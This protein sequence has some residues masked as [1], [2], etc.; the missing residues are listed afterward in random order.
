MVLTCQNFSFLSAMAVFVKKG[1]F[2]KE[3]QF[4]EK[5]G[6]FW[7]SQTSDSFNKKSAL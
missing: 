5:K 3:K 2:G 4:L 7:K 1:S 6:S